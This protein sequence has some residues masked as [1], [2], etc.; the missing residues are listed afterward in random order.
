MVSPQRR[1]GKFNTT[2]F[3]PGDVDAFEV[4]HTLSVAYQQ[5]PDL[6]ICPQVDCCR[7]LVVH[8]KYDWLG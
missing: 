6:E 7:F 2:N 4:V 5:R 1:G 8:V 3:M